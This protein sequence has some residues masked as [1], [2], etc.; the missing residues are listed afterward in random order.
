MRTMGDGARCLVCIKWADSDGA[1]SFTAI[2]KGGKVRYVDPQDPSRD[3]SGF[4]DRAAEGNFSNWILRI[5]NNGFT[6]DAKDC[7]RKS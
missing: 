7:F 1:H 3:A 6:E 2:R 5:D 4:F